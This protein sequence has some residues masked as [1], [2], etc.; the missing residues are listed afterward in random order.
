[1]ADE[2]ERFFQD[3]VDV[4]RFQDGLRRA[5]ETQELVH[6]RID[7]VDLVANQVREGVA[8]IGVL[9]TLR[10]ELRERF[11]RNKRVLDFMRHSGG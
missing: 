9:V 11:D 8:E 10:Q 2:L 7:P 6:E 1:M 4:H 3:L 5:R